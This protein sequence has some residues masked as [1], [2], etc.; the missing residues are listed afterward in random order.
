[1]AA[2]KAAPAVVDLYN[3]AEDYMDLKA[4]R[5]PAVPS[6][7]ERVPLAR[8]ASNLAPPFDLTAPPAD[9]AEPINV[10]LAAPSN[11]ANHFQYFIRVPEPVLTN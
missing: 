1:M 2:L 11:K 8:P 5:T 6:A 10:E 9:P 7:S 3:S 4:Y